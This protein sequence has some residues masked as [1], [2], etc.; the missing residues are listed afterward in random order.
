MSASAAVQ[1]KVWLPSANVEK[2]E[3]VGL[4]MQQQPDDNKDCVSVPIW[5]V[6]T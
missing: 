1:Y 5:K 3:N 2:V 6:N 4:L